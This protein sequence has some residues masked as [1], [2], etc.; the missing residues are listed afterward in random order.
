MIEA[1]PMIARHIQVLQ[2]FRLSTMISVLELIILLSGE[3]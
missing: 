3:G 1:K 2:R